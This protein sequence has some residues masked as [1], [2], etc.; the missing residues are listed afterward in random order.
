MYPGTTLCLMI[1]SLKVFLFIELIGFITQSR[2]KLKDNQ[3][4]FIRLVGLSPYPVW[5]T[6]S[7]VVSATLTN[8]YFGLMC[9]GTS[10]WILQLT[11]RKHFFPTLLAQK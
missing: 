9:L 2:K 11:R 10:R 5:G 3:I 6:V 4:V 7:V 1:S 8:F